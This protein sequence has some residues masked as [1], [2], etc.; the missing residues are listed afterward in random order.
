MTKRHYTGVSSRLFEYQDMYMSC[1]IYRLDELKGPKHQNRLK[2]VRGYCIDEK[3]TPLPIAYTPKVKTPLLK[4][5]RK[6]EYKSGEFEFD[7]D[8]VP[9]LIESRAKREK[10]KVKCRSVDFVD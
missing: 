2:A 8:G 6:G 4:T 1:M 7:S 9:R 10:N 3:C 5:K